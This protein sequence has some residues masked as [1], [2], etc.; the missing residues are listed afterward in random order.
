MFLR[1]KENPLTAVLF[2]YERRKER[3]I[4]DSGFDG[5]RER[6]KSVHRQ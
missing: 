6:P 2:F 5:R 1:E 4:I 3:H